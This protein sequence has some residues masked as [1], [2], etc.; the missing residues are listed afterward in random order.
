M[1]VQLCVCGSGS[2]STPPFGSKLRHS[3]NEHY[4]FVITLRPTNEPGNKFFWR[5]I[6]V[7]GWLERVIR[8]CRLAHIHVIGL[9][10]RGFRAYE[11]HIEGSGLSV[12]TFSFMGL[13]FLSRA[14]LPKGSRY[15][16]FYSIFSRAHCCTKATFGLRT[17]EVQRV[18]SLIRGEPRGW[19]IG[20]RQGNPRG[21]RLLG[22][23]EDMS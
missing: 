16:L 23:F 2:L 18:T 17:P 21:T 13:G 4:D 9:T 22:W 6:P 20:G 1:K 10:P 8:V 11:S 12:E 5:D 19:V 14:L 3:Q 7:L 15:L